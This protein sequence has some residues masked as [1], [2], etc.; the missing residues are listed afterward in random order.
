[1]WSSTEADDQSCL[2]RVTVSTDH[3]GRVRRGQRRRG[4]HRRSHQ[5]HRAAAA[6]TTP[7]SGTTSSA[8]TTSSGTTTSTA[9]EAAEADE[10]PKHT[11]RHRPHGEGNS[12]VRS[13]VHCLYQ[14]TKVHRLSL[15]RY[16]FRCI[17]IHALLSLIY[18]IHHTIKTHGHAATGH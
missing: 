1:M 13:F 9:A 17:Y 15:L 8:A 7:S 14:T 5:R 3:R 2:Q 11:S 6:A 16:T 18:N 10:K 12:F 4:G